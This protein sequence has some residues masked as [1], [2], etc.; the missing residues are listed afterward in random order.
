MSDCLGKAEGHLLLGVG[1]VRQCLVRER[2]RARDE[3]NAERPVDDEEG[4]GPER[5]VLRKQARETKQLALPA[6]LCAPY[7]NEAG[8]SNRGKRA[9][10]RGDVTSRLRF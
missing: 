2:D 5:Q 10:A 7:C 8:G 9:A 1:V 6:S 3:P 4:R